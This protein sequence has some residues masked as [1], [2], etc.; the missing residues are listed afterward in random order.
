MLCNGAKPLHP[1]KKFPLRQKL[2]PTGSKFQR[3]LELLFADVMALSF[4]DFVSF[5]RVHLLKEE[6][7]SY[8]HISIFNNFFRTLRNCWS[9]FSWILP[10]EDSKT[11]MYLARA[12]PSVHTFCSTYVL[13]IPSCLSLNSGGRHRLHKAQ[14][15]ILTGLDYG[16]SPNLFL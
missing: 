1:K 2:K 12:V 16:C 14:E 5:D 8:T 4:N 9:G 3:Y 10:K 15:K 7:F 13:P 6:E 11:F